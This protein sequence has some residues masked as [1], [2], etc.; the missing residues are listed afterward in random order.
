MY[1]IGKIVRYLVLVLV[2]IGIAF[3]VGTV[4]N[5]TSD[6]KF[7]DNNKTYSVSIRVMNRET[8]KVITGGEFVL[9]TSDGKVIEEWVLNDEV[10]CI[11]NLEN[12]TY[13]IVQKSASDGYEISDEVTFKIYNDEKEITIY[14]D[15]I[16]EEVIENKEVIVDNT[17]SMKSGI[18]YII[19]FV[20]IGI[21]VLLV[22][23]RKFC[24]K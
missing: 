6:K 3:L 22:N 7:L 24:F 8:K 1:M 20:I 13:V 10:K 16:I 21:G 14:N 5:K 19:S 17:L 12:G 9:K 15:A 11:D 23:K 2:V 4:I 18:N